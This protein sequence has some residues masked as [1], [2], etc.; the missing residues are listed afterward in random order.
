MRTA[1]PLL[2]LALAC[3]ARGQEQTYDVE[4]PGITGAFTVRRDGDA[5][6]LTGRLG[7]QPL[8]T[9]GERTPQGWRFV[10]PGTPGLAGALTGERGAPRVLIIRKDGDGVAGELDGVALRGARRAPVPA[11]CAPTRDAWYA[12]HGVATW[13]VGRALWDFYKPGSR[14]F[15]EL[16]GDVTR[17]R[18]RALKQRLRREAPLT[19]ETIY[20]EARAM[21]RSAREALQLSFAL[22]LDERD[23]RLERLPGL[24][25]DAPLHDKYEHF[26]ASAILAHRANAR[27]GFAV[28]WLKEVMDHVAGGQYDEDD[29][30]ADALGADFGQRLQCAE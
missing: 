11:E 25:E 7:D 15:E 23:L 9:R 22:L 30:L 3:S 10:L 17:E 13:E 2:L 20:Q 1:A 28:G 14:R 24:A 21:T 16:R 8:E 6:A 27:G 4:G 19:A 5:L 18:T 26:F 12:R 29:L